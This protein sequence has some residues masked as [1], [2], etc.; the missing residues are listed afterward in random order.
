MKYNDGLFID[1]RKD[2]N[3]RPEKE[4]MTIVARTDIK[5]NAHRSQNPMIKRYPGTDS[6]V[7]KLDELILS[8]FF[9]N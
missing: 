1:K 9:F 7:F 8:D 4:K 2:I 3:S 6:R 5:P